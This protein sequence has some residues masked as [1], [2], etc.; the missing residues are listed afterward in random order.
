MEDRAIIELY[1]KRNE[2]A[3]RETDRKYGRFCHRLALNILCNPGGL[4]HHRSGPDHHPAVRFRR[5]ELG[6]DGFRRCSYFIPGAE[7][8]LPA[9]KMLII[10]GEDIG[11]YTLQGYR[12][13]ACE[14][15]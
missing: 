7:T 2:A 6:D 14:K 12:T 1:W 15:Q 13:G 5:G 4:L 11:E 9:T 3:I 8:V 10:I